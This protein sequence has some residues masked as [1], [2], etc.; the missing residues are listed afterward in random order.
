M[1]HN[2]MYVDEMIPQV[3]DILETY[4]YSKRT[5]WMNM[6]GEFSR[7]KS[8]YQRQGTLVYDPEITEECV[9]EATEQYR[10]G[11]IQRSFYNTVRKA[12]S[13][14][15]EYYHTGT[16]E[17]SCNKRNTKYTLCDE[18]N[19][20]LDAFLHSRDF[21]KNTKWDFAWAV[22]RYLYF[23]EQMGFRRMADVTMKHVRQFI[24]AAAPEMTDGSLHN[25]L[26]YIRQFHIFLQEN[27]EA[28]P[29]C[30]ELLSYPIPRKARIKGY[31]TDD[32]LVR[33]MAQI[34][35]KT[36]MGKR[37]AAIISLGATTGL[38]A[39]DI[40]HLRLEDIDWRKGEIRISQSKTS[41]SLSLPLVHETGELIKDYILNARP[42][43]AYGEIF[44]R[45]R[46]PICPLADGVP[47]GDMF[48]QYAKKAGIERKPYDGKT[49]HGLRRH[50]AKNLIVSGV[51]VT[52]IAQ[53]L[54]HQSME[55]VKQY[56]SLDGQNLKE[57][58]L[59]F[60]AI[61]LAREGVVM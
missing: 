48:D 19:R 35:T 44:L 51:P 43:A 4:G 53:I 3:L 50:L 47:V 25:L 42:A 60:S 26:C 32:E 45:A 16:L 33:I 34:N 23:F 18:F 27:G 22:R 38:R 52:T 49:F 9:R 29:D 55:S 12:A 36:A 5:L 1:K 6:Y 30:I 31:I 14:L 46:A 24:V 2:T 7:I 56:L 11:R 61:P 59:D 40:V 21:H 28:A 17:W 39:V 54:G 8:F 20:L 10:E 15:N 41:E 57:C 58:A 13:R 37:D